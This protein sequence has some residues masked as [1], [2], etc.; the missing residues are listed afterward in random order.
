M[1]KIYKWMGWVGLGWMEISVSTYSKSTALRCFF[2]FWCPFRVKLVGTKSQVLPRKQNL[3]AP[4]NG[5]VKVFLE[6][7][8][9]GTA[10][11][12]AMVSSSW[13]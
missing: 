3:M 9:S 11:N 12:V 4:L 13:M 6:A 7:I 1:L 8:L 5:F 10:D 2:C